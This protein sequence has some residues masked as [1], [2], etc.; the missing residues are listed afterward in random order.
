[1]P[2]WPLPTLTQY[3]SVHMDDPDTDLELID[4]EAAAGDREALRLRRDGKPSR[5]DD[6]PVGWRG[7][8]ARLAA[9]VLIVLVGVGVWGLLAYR[10]LDA[11]RTDLFTARDQLDQ[12]VSAIADGDVVEATDLLTRSRDVFAAVPDTV[13]GPLVAPVRLVPTLR[14]TLVAVA[15]LA[16]G[17]EAVAGVGVDVTEVLDL[18]AGGLGAL[19]PDDGRIPI[20]TFAAL[21]P[22]LAEAEE[23]LVEATALVEGVPRSGIDAQVRDARDAFLEIVGPVAEQIATASRLAELVPAAFGGEAPRSYA[24]LAANP[25][26]SRGAGGFF[27]AYTIMGAADGVLSFSEVRPTED[28]PVLPRGQIPWPDPSL[29]E[30]YDAYGGS[31][32]VRNL[33]MTPD[34]PS[35]ATAL[36]RYYAAA[37]GEVLDG[38]IAV[39]PFA[40]EALLRIAGP[41]D[42]PGYGTVGHDEVVEFV[43]HEAY[44]VITDPDE[45]KRLI[46][47]VATAS[48]QG[49]LD[50]PEDVS[51]GAILDALGYMAGRQSVMMH[52]V[53]ADEQAL[54][55]GLGVAGAL[56]RGD[57][58]RGDLL[59]VHLNSGS[60]SKVD[61]WLER[62]LRYDV[63]LAPG[64]LTASTL[65]TGFINNAPTSG[66]PGYM[67]GNGIAPL[68]AGD[69][70]S[71]VSIYCREG[72][73]FFEIPDAGFDGLETEQGSELGFGVS[74]TW[75]RLPSEQQRELIWSYSTPDGWTTEGLNRVYRLHYDHQPTIIPT[76][77]QVGV[78][79]PEG[80]EAT[81][82]PEGASIQEGRVVVVLDAVSDTDLVI[83][84][85]PVGSQPG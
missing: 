10:E 61:Y 30:R 42:V 64:G 65:S 58:E 40:F 31:G 11:V 15:D 28:L 63:V 68:D 80:F 70:L 75:M 67:I 21:T 1:M 17:A 2:R 32:F 82:V 33:N 13:G 60:P 81:T 54:L 69:V 24:V 26:E 49:F 79:I 7:R 12:A 74:S 9:V 77:L 39:D 57:E 22:V 16:T 47:L 62:R 78:E 34:F 36:E 19:A 46:G 76:Q 73:R 66:E 51:A 38:V 5:S 3:R 45:R 48:L 35:A 59:A 41:V 29:A 43:S 37:T 56:G 85:A 55:A 50:S 6:A 52:A 27:G 53:D 84:F 72:C 4:L 44:S 18:Q 14:R 23:A 8:P 71:F 20:E 83:V 25:T